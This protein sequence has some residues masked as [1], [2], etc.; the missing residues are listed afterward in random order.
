[1]ISKLFL[2]LFL[3]GFLNFCYVW[4]FAKDEKVCKS[5]LR[6]S[7]IMILPSVLQSYYTFYQKGPS[8]NSTSLIVVEYLLNLLFTS[9]MISLAV[10]SFTGALDSRISK[11]VEERK[12]KRGSRIT[13]DMYED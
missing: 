5:I 6:I 7:V 4:L 3:S 1:M 11:R 8:F 13:E 2:V 10:M 9:F 12:S